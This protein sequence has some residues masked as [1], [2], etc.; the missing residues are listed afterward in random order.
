MQ[1]KN[2]DGLTCLVHAL[3]LSVTKQQKNVATTWNTKK[4]FNKGIQGEEGVSG[5][6]DCTTFHCI[7]E[8]TS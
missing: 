1:K 2:I 3:W 8:I 4:A 5:T 6:V 7:S